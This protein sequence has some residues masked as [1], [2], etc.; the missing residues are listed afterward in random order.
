MRTGSVN[1]RLWFKIK[2]IFSLLMVW[3]S[4]QAYSGF[5]NAWGSIVSASQSGW[6][7]DMNRFS[8]SAHGS[9]KCEDCHGPMAGAGKSHPDPK[10]K[11][12]LRIE[13]KK[14]FDYQSCKKCHKNSYERFLSGE[15]AKA[16][17]KEQETGVMSKTGPAPICGD[18]HSAHYSVSH[19]S[20][21]EINKA[22]TT[23]C[24]SCHPSQMKSYLANYHGK[25]AVNLGFDK[26]AS[27][28][29]CHGAHH[30]TSLKEKETALK[31]CRRCHPDA[32]PQ[33]ADIIIHDSKTDL[34]NKSDSKKTGLKTVH[35][36]SLIS[37]I[38]IV[39]VLAFF[40]SHSFL[41]MLRKI[42]EKLRKHT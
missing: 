23:T 35:A 7:V 20:H 36:L 4:L 32:Q 37:L 14:N 2:L 9:I 26:S 25:T 33:F 10:V 22:M 3:Y 38:F 34:D 27:C 12:F 13:T 5:T 15:H 17:I 18:C 1:N 29:D 21:A 30:C 41:L 16:L 31:S 39:M 24:G 28:T 19:L 6:F 11:D 40:Y 8:S 42:H